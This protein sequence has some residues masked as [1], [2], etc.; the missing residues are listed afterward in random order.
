MRQSGDEKLLVA[1]NPAD[2]PCEASPGLSPSA[3]LPE[4]LDG[5]PDAFIRDGSKWLFH[6]PGVTGGVYQVRGE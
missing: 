1:L 5:Q 2:Q 6:L 3:R 4:T